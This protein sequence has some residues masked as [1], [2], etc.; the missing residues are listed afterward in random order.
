MGPVS[1][2]CNATLALLAHPLQ[3]PAPPGSQHS[4]PAHPVQDDLSPPVS[5]GKP[6]LS[7]EHHCVPTVGSVGTQVPYL[8]P[9]S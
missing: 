8:V 7:R 3:P 6:E 2:L 5:D 4:R 1:L 9:W